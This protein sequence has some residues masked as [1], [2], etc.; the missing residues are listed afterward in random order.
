MAIPPIKLKAMVTPT[1]IKWSGGK[2]I[3]RVRVRARTDA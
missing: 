3:C 1:N 2:I